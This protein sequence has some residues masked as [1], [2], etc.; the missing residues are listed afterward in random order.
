VFELPENLSELSD[1]ELG[2]LLEQAIARFQE[3]RQGDLTAESLA[4]METL[5]S[6]IEQIRSEDNSRQESAEAAEALAAEL[7][8]RVQAATAQD[9]GGEGGEGE[10]PDED[11][12]VAE[13][14]GEAE[15]GETPE[16]QPDTP[17]QANQPEQ[18]EEAQE[19]VAAGATNRPAPARTPRPREGGPLMRRIRERAPEVEVPTGRVAIL[20]AADI[21][22]VPMGTRYD[23]ML[24]VA[25]AMHAAA[26]TLPPSRGNG[27]EVPVAIFESPFGNVPVIEP[28][29]VG[30]AQRAITAA[31]S[32]DHLTAAGGW[33]APS[34]TIYNLFG[35]ECVGN[36][37]DLPTVGIRRGGLRFPI[38]PSFGDAADSTWAWTEADDISAL[39]GDPTKPCIRIPC[40]EFDEERLGCD[41]ICVTHGNLANNAYPEMTER[42]IAL[43]MANHARYMNAKAITRMVNDSTVHPAFTA[44]LG[45]VAPVLEAAEIAAFSYREQWGMCYNDTLEMVVPAW[46]SAAFRA[47][48]SKR[49]NVPVWDVNEAMVT[50]WFTDRNLRVQYVR[51][52]QALPNNATCW[53]TSVDMLLYAAGTWV[54]GTG[55]TLN[56]GVVRDS[57]LNATNDY[58]ALWTEECWLMFRQGHESRVLTVDID[59]N[60]VAAALDTPAACVQ[61]S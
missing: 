49:A 18:A 55:M 39:D 35:V 40:P 48:M 21:P 30:S 60:G 50:A 38:S 32:P 9:E 23:G 6:A 16:P 19:A 10:T 13:D 22:G 57:V 1:E 11:N 42:F 26:R 47:D 37:L 31:T 27:R 28:D 15:G 61:G 34:E 36:L 56:L 17:E 41:G 52:W 58:T 43:V 2:D 45:A 24:Q 33:C 14:T 5:A 4:E 54:R 46:L 20:A 53:P 3:I 7:E 51:D 44:G 29:D 25:E 59:P 12:E 8:A